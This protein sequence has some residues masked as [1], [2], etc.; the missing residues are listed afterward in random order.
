MR[1]EEYVADVESRDT[2]FW[3][4]RQ[5]ARAVL[6]FSDLIADRFASLNMSPDELEPR[7][8]IPARRVEEIIDGD[9]P[10]LTEVLQL[11]H[12][13]RIEID[14][15][16]QLKIHPRV[17]PNVSTPTSLVYS[18]DSGVRTQAD[19]AQTYGGEPTQTT[20]PFPTH[21]TSDV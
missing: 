13:L 20:S 19:V 5:A 9:T 17:L 18:V 8:G 4:E 2:T 11:C 3:A 21:T 15:T 12:A 10:D 1:H 7:V 16:D 6:E 14:I